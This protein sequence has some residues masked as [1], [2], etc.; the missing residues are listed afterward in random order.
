MGDVRDRDNPAEF[1]LKLNMKENR[2]FLKTFLLFSAAVLISLYVGSKDYTFFHSI[3]EL[4]GIFIGISIA[5]I[6]YHS[7]KLL[8]NGAFLYLGAMFL[9]ISLFQIIHMFTYKGVNIFPWNDYNLAIQISIACKYLEAFSLL[10]MFFIPS[11]VFE[12]SENFK[13][14]V[15]IYLL[16]TSI[17]MLFIVRWRIFPRCAYDNAEQTM[18]K[19]VSEY[20]VLFL[21]VLITIMLYAKKHNFEHRLFNCMFSFIAIKLLAEVLFVSGAQVNDT[22]NILAHFI[23]LFAYCVIF[24]AITIGETNEP[25]IILYDKLDRKNKEFEQKTIE[26]EMVNSQLKLEVEESIRAEE[27]LR[28]SEERYRSLLELL[29]EAVFLH[30]RENVLFVNQL[31]VRLLGLENK[32]QGLE[33][34][35]F[36]L[37]GEENYHSFLLEMDEIVKN[38][39]QVAFE[40]T[41]LNSNKCF[42]VEFVTTPHIADDKHV[43]I[44]VIR[45]LAQMKKIKEMEKSVVENKRLLK[46]ITEKHKMKTDYF[47]NLSHEFRTPLSIMLCTLKIMESFCKLEENL[48]DQKEK[49]AQ[50]IASVK[51]NSYRL[52][53]IANNFL[54]IA[55]I[56]SGYGELKLKNYNIVSIVE[57]VTMSVWEYTRNRR[58]SLM[59]DTDTEEIILACD[60]DKIEMIVLNLLSNAIKFTREGGQIE[61]NIFN[62]KQHVLISV[63]DTGIGI[64][65]DKLDLIFER[66]KQVDN[67][68]A[69]DYEGIGVGLSL[70]KA[71]V[72]MHG[73]NIEVESSLGVGSTFKVLLPKRILPDEPYFDNSEIDAEIER[74]IDEK[75]YIELSNVL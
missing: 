3:I 71:L 10:V 34:S 39:R 75:V 33:I 67:S 60:I 42:K 20:I 26:L 70:V 15:A 56:D 12:K 13:I 35:L 40:Q 68:L 31:G 58:I 16:A 43:F 69:K 24:R 61:V 55:K 50:Y 54:E 59:F 19:I 11:A 66:F 63:S 17:I 48:N 52:F 29:P 49:M 1:K 53:K 28:K 36:D 37:F 21:Y 2:L 51:T 41:V 23:R 32:Q 18:F 27:L 4:V 44:S 7:S 14:I 57:K 73:G 72:E 5:S 9:F 47:T 62:H 65:E 22:A 8:K 25:L 30:D 46:E 74:S 6:A 38:G 64:P 45:D